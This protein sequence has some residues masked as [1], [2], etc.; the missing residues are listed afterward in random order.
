MK[1][2]QI[3]NL[4]SSAKHLNLARSAR[5]LADSWLQFT[6][7]HDSGYITIT[8]IQRYQ[9]PDLIHELQVLMAESDNQYAQQYFND[10][11]EQ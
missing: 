10:T 9:L 4:A 1:F 2:N 8:P 11:Q 6:E 5:H 7:F 3:D